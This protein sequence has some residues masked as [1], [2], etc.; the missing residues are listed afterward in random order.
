MPEVQPFK[1]LKPVPTCDTVP[2]KAFTGNETQKEG[3][4]FVGIYGIYQESFKRM[5]ELRAEKLRAEVEVL[6]GVGDTQL[7]SCVQP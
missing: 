1:T 2:F 6:K 3:Q 4:N 7:P 5:H